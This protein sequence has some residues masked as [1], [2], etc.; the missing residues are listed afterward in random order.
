MNK[1]SIAAVI[2]VVLLGLT[3][4]KLQS[5][6]RSD[7]TPVAESVTLPKVAKD[8]IAALE[9]S[10]PKGESARLEKRG[11][12][13]WVVK[14]VETE[15]DQAVVDTALNKIAELEVTGT[16]AT[17]EANHA[18]LEVDDA[19]A[20]HVVAEGGGK[21]L[22]DFRLGAYRSGNT[23][24]RE[25]GKAPTATVKGSIKYAFDR[26]VRDWRNRAIVKDEQAAFSEALF[27][28]PNGSFKFVRDG[29]EWKQADGEPPIPDFDRS[30]PR[31]LIAS[32]VNLRAADFP[33]PEV[34]ADQAG[35]GASAVAKITL[36]KTSDAGT[37]MVQ[38]RFGNKEGENYYA[39]REGRDV[40]Y[41]V[42]S[43]VA[44]RMQ[45][46]PD[47]FKKKD[48]PAQ[49]P[50]DGAEGMPQGIPGGMDQLP[51]ELQQQLRQQIQQQMQQQGHG[52]PPPGH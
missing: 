51:P 33:K 19:Q 43:F 52:Q 8:A 1:L 10:V 44:E 9:V 48:E 47:D 34:T 5:E 31:A 30:K 24:I 29:E 12:T 2:L 7:A 13:W 18:R 6:E 37:E 15:A 36:L 25:S 21:K 14:P 35:V 38:I 49:P 28:S 23:M 45:P 42:S 27:E 20:I 11:D 40:L 3:L 16:A 39:K 46:G 17:K 26:S 32:A 4:Y 41:L 50:P 22:I